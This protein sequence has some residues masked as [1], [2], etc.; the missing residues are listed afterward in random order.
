MKSERVV[1]FFPL[2]DLQIAQET[3]HEEWSSDG[4]S[5]V[6]PCG[7]EGGRVE[8]GRGER[9]LFGTRGVVGPAAFGERA[10]AGFQEG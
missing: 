4:G 8:G 9:S 2:L 6:E 5:V 3:P 7:G 10:A 1:S